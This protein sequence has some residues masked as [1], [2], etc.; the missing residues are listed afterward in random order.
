MKHLSHLYVLFLPLVPRFLCKWGLGTTFLL[1]VLNMFLSFS[2]STAFNIKHLSHHK[3]LKTFKYDDIK[4]LVSIYLQNNVLYY[5]KKGEGQVEQ[6]PHLDW[7]DAG[8][9]GQRAG[10]GEVDGGQ[11]LD[12]I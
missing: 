12:R 5:D 6:E 2:S 8:R 9:A 4:M 11:H 10:H 1:S 3:F 7:L